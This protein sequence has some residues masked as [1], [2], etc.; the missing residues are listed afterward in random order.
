MA[1]LLSELAELVAGKLVG[2][3]SIAI[4]S[5]DPLST[6]KEGSITFVDNPRSFT[7][8][9]KSRA[10]AA[11]LS[12]DLPTNGLSYIQVNDPLSAFIEVLH[13]LR[14]PTN[15]KCAAIDPRAAI[16]P[17]AKIGQGVTV[18]PFAVIEEGVIIGK[19]C[20]IHA[21]AIIGEGSQLG[22]DVEIHSYVVLYPGTKLGNRVCIHANA[23][24]GADG[25]GYRFK[26][27]KHVKVPQLGHVEIGDD[28]EI[29]S[30][31]TIDR[32]TFDATYIGTGTK[33][34]NQVQIG[35]NCN[36]GPH[37]ILVSQ[38]G[39][40]GSSSTGEYVVI[41]GQVGIRDHIHIGAGSTIGAKA[42]VTKDVPPGVRMLGAPATPERDQKKILMSLEKLPDMR[43]DIKR[44]KQHLQLED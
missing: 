32:A 17:K 2:D 1:A 10:S 40:A 41:A 14:G 5:A 11:I 27:G 20:H 16:H 37:N 21:G 8:L 36:I 12:P 33:I 9:H 42:G 18:G 15:K 35:H 31:S 25:F 3:G 19:R 22:D 28:V 44:L 13:F 34:D 24:I 29:G 43:K 39:I 4:T 26:D 38:V 30:C 6:A 23:V 7:D